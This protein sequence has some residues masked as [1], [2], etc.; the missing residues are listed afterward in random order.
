MTTQRD[1]YEILGVQQ[2]A[3]SEE[4]KK[5]YRALAMKYHPDRNQENTEAEE[6][7]KEI[8]EAYE[9]LK[10]SQK[11]AHYDRFG[12]QGASMGS[13]YSHE[14][15]L[16]D[17]LRI[18]MSEGFGG[19]DVFGAQSGR[20]RQSQKQRGTDLQIRLKFSL[21]EIAKGVEKKINIKK[22]VV[23]P[24]CNGSGARGGR[25][26]KTCPTCKGAGEVRQVANSFFGQFV[27]ITT[28][29]RCNGEGRIVD[30]P[31]ERCRGEGRISGEKE[32]K[33][34]VPAGVSAGN[35]LTLRGEG[36]IGA[37]GGPAGSL[38]VV[39]DEAEHKYFERHGDDIVYTLYLSFSQ[40]ALGDQVE[41]PTL[42]GRVQLDINAGTQSGKILRLKGR[43]ISHLRQGGQGDLLVQVLV[44]TPVKL[45]SE[46]KHLLRELSQFENMKPP[47]QNKSFFKK[48]KDTFF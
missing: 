5:A 17:A 22:Q 12:H 11:R 38:I 18:F 39:I 33:V 36:N 20:S 3:A 15:D 26:F 32:V 27:N 21:E 1:Y 35:Y 34:M 29:T 42:D 23:C 43:G 45:S 19:F 9:I 8:G 2:G 30:H 40:I 31:C 14:W 25:G 13:S 6:K 41:I 4:I 46:E 47:K 37:R 10:D 48:F 24:I 44:W 28:C 16:G 7:F